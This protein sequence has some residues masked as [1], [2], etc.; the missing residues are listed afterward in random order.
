MIKNKS[1]C[2]CEIC[3]EEFTPRPQI[4][5]PRACSKY[6]CQRE[7]QRRNER[8]WREKNADLYDRIYHQIQKQK[9][10]EKMEL[11][12]NTIMALLEVGQRFHRMYLNL[13]KAR[14]FFFE[15]LKSLGLRRINKLWISKATDGEGALE[16]EIG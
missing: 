9:R 14:V 1:M 15:I 3:K 5:N 8:D 16:H 2:I 7:R 6:A 4:K 10:E 13:S 12:L 11:I